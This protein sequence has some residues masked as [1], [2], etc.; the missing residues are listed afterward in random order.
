MVIS[1]V[2]IIQE[3]VQK[4][5]PS[6]DHSVEQLPPIAVWAMGGNALVKGIIGLGCY[7]IKTTQVQALVQDCWTDVI[8]NTASLLFPLIGHRLHIWWLD[9]LGALLL[10]LY[11]VY[12]WSSTCLEIAARLSGVAVERRL[13][14]KMLFLCYRFSPLFDSLKNLVAYHAGDGV[15]V[16]Y[17]IVL[18]ES[19]PLHR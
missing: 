4:L 17:D 6:G 1:F 13:L 16:E 14:Q 18:N 8:F 15:W 3:S 7:P 19:T 10:S 5:L 11:I 12:D 9:P 2:Q